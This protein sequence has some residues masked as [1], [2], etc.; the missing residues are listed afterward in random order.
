MPRITGTVT[1]GSSGLGF[2]PGELQP[3]ADKPGPLYL[4]LMGQAEPLLWGPWDP[5]AS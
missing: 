3:L 2:N 5:Q 4:G 1:G